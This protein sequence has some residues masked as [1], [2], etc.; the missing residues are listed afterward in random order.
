MSEPRDQWVN[1]LLISLL[2]VDIIVTLVEI[3]VL[4]G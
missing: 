1:L 2:T 3:I 4:N